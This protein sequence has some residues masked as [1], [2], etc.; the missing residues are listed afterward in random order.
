MRAHCLGPRRLD[1]LPRLT[2]Q[3]PVRG[4]ERS[5]W[6]WLGVALALFACGNA[7]P[8]RVDGPPPAAIEPAA[9][10]AAEPAEP[11]PVS[12]PA[13]PQDAAIDCAAVTVSVERVTPKVMLLVDGSSSMQ[14]NFYPAGGK[15]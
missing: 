10:P 5:T 13:A 1:R 6:I 9:K 7:T 3:Q 8:L 14:D 12:A 15:T 2:Y 11:E 4:A